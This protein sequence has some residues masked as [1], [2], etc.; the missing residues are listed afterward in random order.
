MKDEHVTFK[1]YQHHS[2]PLIVNHKEMIEVTSDIM[3]ENSIRR[4][5]SPGLADI[6]KE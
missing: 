2:R 6:W 1:F 5:A 3:D 4:V